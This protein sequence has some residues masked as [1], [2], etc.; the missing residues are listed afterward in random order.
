MLETHFILTVL[1][2]SVAYVTVIYKC[3]GQISVYT[4]DRVIYE[5]SFE[6]ESIDETSCNLT[7]PLTYLKYLSKVFDP[8]E[9]VFTLLDET[10]L[11]GQIHENKILIHSYL[12]NE[13]QLGI[14]Q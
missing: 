7:M 9:D 5:S 11:L 1:I 13:N 2:P 6:M 4:L 10:V 14:F 3:E 8:L 12:Q